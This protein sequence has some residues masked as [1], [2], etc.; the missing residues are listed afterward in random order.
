VIFNGHREHRGINVTDIV[1]VASSWY[2]LFG[3]S[4]INLIF[5]YLFIYSHNVHLDVG[6]VVPTFYLFCVASNII[7]YTVSIWLHVNYTP[8]FNQPLLRRV[9]LVWRICPSMQNL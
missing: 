1:Y 6:V 5:V 3:P 4:V 2:C 9:A 8:S 7:S